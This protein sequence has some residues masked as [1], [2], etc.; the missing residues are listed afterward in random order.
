MVRARLLR[1]PLLGLVRIAAVGKVFW[2]PCSMPLPGR[3]FD[4][5]GARQLRP[6]PAKTA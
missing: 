4:L 2:L 1:T 3:A 6:R 5:E